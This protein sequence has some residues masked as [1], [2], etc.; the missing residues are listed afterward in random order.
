MHPRSL[1]QGLVFCMGDVALRE[2][3]LHYSKETDES[4]YSTA[5]LNTALCFSRAFCHC[6]TT[7]YR[8]SKEILMWMSLQHKIGCPSSFPSINFRIQ[9]SR[10]IVLWDAII[11]WGMYEC[12]FS[13]IYLSVPN[14]NLA[15]NLLSSYSS[16]VYLDYLTEIVLLLSR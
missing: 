9:S 7:H 16:L 10:A 13:F 5:H 14:L 12:S 4:R 3:K 6:I 1:Q 8:C 11:F 2:E 15:T